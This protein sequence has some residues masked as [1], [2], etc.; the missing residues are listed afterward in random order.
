MIPVRKILRSLP[1]LRVIPRRWRA[2]RALAA[3]CHL[4]A[5]F[6]QRNSLCFDN[7]AFQGSVTE[8]FLQLGAR[9]VAVEPQPALTAA[10]QRRFAA[11]GRLTA[12]AKA[13]GA[14]DATARLFVATTAYHSSLRQ[15]WLDYVRP[16]EPD[17][18][19]KVSD[20]AVT[21]LDRLIAEYGC[22]DFVKIDVEGAEL[23][24]LHGLYQPLPA[25]SIE[26]HLGRLENTAACLAYLDGLARYTAQFTVGRTW[27]FCSADWMLPGELL[28]LLQERRAH[29]EREWGDIY[30]RR[31][32]K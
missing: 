18:L 3:R 20:V 31:L 23:D 27:A 5:P 28:A 15:D 6:V 4:L 22:P 17:A 9:V 13:V 2:S 7:G 26:Y 14:Q 19:Q 8:A 1:I 32:E 24:V 21:T 30:L 29:I 25:L 10:L 16:N 12:I 11:T